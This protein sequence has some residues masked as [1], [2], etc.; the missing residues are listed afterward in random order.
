MS[1][2]T[3]LGLCTDNLVTIIQPSSTVECMFGSGNGCCGS[4]PT[5][6]TFDISGSTF[7][8]PQSITLSLNSSGPAIV[9]G[10]VRLVIT[11]ATSNLFVQLAVANWY[12]STFVP[13]GTSATISLP[14]SVTA[15]TNTLTL[16]VSTQGGSITVTSY[17]VPYTVLTL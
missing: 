3:P 6:T 14:F 13:S 7:S 2:I 5:Q 12:S 8:S 11:G 16:T 9:T 4:T 15:I 10:A 17:T 1:E